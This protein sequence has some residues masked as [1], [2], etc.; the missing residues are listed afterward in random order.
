MAV[1]ALLPQASAVSAACH[2]ADSDY[3]LIVPSTVYKNIS[4]KQHD[5]DASLQTAC[6]NTID[7]KSDINITYC[8]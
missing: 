1:G 4:P 7:K 3:S 8:P 2:P 6:H 5:N